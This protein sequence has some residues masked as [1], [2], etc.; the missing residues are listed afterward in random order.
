MA[1]KPRR[2]KYRRYLKGLIE[3]NTAMGAL[4][5]SSLIT[6]SPVGVVTETAWLSS[7]KCTWSWK[8]IAVAQSDGPII[9][10]VAH[11]DY[12]AAEIEEFLEQQGSWDEGDLIAQE[13]RKRKIRVIG[14]FPATGISLTDITVLN[15]GLPIHTKCGWYLTTGK[16]VDFWFY[17][18]GSG[19]L[20]TGSFV[21]ITGHANLWPR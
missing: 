5:T 7:V 12:T 9:V 19:N 18:A 2:R 13:V 8:D 6:A 21:T 15:D 14:T 4:A 16:S 11:S 10:G 17:N 3:L 1:R 20:V